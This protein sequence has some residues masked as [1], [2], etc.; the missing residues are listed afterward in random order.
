MDNDLVLGGKV[1]LKHTPMTATLSLKF[2]DGSSTEIPIKAV[3]EI[4]V[5]DHG[6]KEISFREARGGWI[7]AINKPLL[8]G[9]L[10]HQFLTVAKDI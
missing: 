2:E 10:D 4:D 7:M 8:T 9:K 5:P 3:V 6:R 1:Y